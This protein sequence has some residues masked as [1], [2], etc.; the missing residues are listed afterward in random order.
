MLKKLVSSV[1]QYFIYLILFLATVLRL[2]ELDRRDFWY[3]E[4]FSGIAVKE[5][6]SGM[7]KMIM[8]DVHPPFYYLTL[9]FFAS[10]FGYSIYGIRLYSVIFGLL[11]IWAVYLFTKELFNRKAAIFASFIV[12]ISP[13]AVQYSMEARMYSMFSFFIII[14]AYFLVKSFRAPESVKANKYSI[15]F[16]V[17]LGLSM[18]THY[19]GI[20][21]APIFYLVYI[22]HK[23]AV[24]AEK[25]VTGKQI[26]DIVRGVLPDKN[27]FLSYIVALIVFAPWIPS[28]INHVIKN[29]TSNSLD[30]IRPANFGDIP[31]NIQM[32]IFGTPLGE[33][34]SGMPGPNEFYGIADITMWILVT[35]FMTTVTLYLLFPCH[36]YPLSKHEVNSG[37]NL[38]KI[39]D[40][41]VSLH[42]SEDDK[43]RRIR[44]KEILT[45]LILSL[46]FMILIWLLGFF[47][48]YYFVA[49]Y[50]LPAGYFIFILLGVWLARLRLSFSLLAIAFYIV[51]LFSTVPLGYSE[52]WNVL[53]KDLDKYKNNDFYILNSFDYV[54]AKYYLGADRLTLYNVDWPSYNPDYWAAIGKTL[55]RTESFEDLRN[56]KSALIISNTQLGGQ[57]NVNFNPSGLILVAQ[58]KNILIYKFQ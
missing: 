23:F 36:F 53:A 47:G 31:V 57:D 9:K 42:L 49:R 45:V 29:A 33:M 43:K 39:L 38:E 50:L 55:K 10:F 15:L 26:S 24:P 48:K 21:F 17:F 58:Y 27:I 51:L 3:D 1:N 7:I 6:W 11:C 56:D 35:V 46:G 34:S 4:A 28:F 2:W 41:R 20:F 18:L 32:F 22:V 44:A 5:N 54:I 14:S 25:N 8:A 52:G 30:W 13:F 40:P 16:G 19:M 37:G 12:A